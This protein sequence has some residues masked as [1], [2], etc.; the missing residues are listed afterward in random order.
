ME[1]KDTAVVEEQYEEISLLDLAM[2][3]VRQKKTILITTLLFIVAGFVYVL[4]FYPPALYK[5]KLQAMLMAPYVVDKENVSIRTENG[6][7]EAIFRSESMK[8]ALDEKFHL[9]DK[10]RK[11]RPNA[12]RR[13]LDKIFEKNLQIEI[14]GQTIDISVKAQDPKLAQDMATFI[15]KRTDVEL[16]EMGIIAVNTVNKANDVLLEK[17]IK[18]KINDIDVGESR[19]SSAKVAEL[20]GMYSAIMARDEGYRL[21]GKQPL[22]LQLLSPASYPDSYEPRGR[23]KTL[24]LFT[25]LGFFLGLVLAFMKYVWSTVDESKKQELKAALR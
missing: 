6:V 20:L 1:T 12:K 16:K 17:E 14:D 13:D 8:D 3:F 4:A 5:S 2:I 22:G 19:R 9:M 7:I 10:L 24:V 15:F 25:M 23:G 11:K 18:E 21:Q